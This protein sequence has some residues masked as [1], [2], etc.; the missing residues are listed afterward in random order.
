MSGS[1]QPP[2]VHAANVLQRADL[3]AT[4][5]LV[6]FDGFVDGIIDVVAERRS[7]RAGDY[8]R[9][10]SIPAFASR[11]AAAAGLSTN[12]EI[13]VRDER[14][15]GNG[16][17][18]AGALAAAGASTSFVGCVGQADAGAG[19]TASIHPLFADLKHRCE[20]TRGIVIPISP[21]ALTHALEFD[22][23]KIMLNDPRNVQGVSWAT[24]RDRREVRELVQNAQLIA[25]VNWTNMDSVRDILT[26]LVAEW[27]GPNSTGHPPR[28]QRMFIDLSDPA[29]RS[30]PDLRQMLDTLTNINRITP[31]TLG[32]NLSEARQVDA[33]LTGGKSLEN[34]ERGDHLRAGAARLR[35]AAGV[36][37][38][39]IHPR[40]GAAGAT[41]SG[42]SAWVDGPLCA[43]PQISTGAGDHFNAGFSL[44]QVIGMPL[45]ACLALGCATSGAYVRDA[46]SPSRARL[47]EMLL[48]PS[49]A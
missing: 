41:S 10:A 20:S 4:N 25:V 15:G 39:V 28:A 18:M 6:G 24:L 23:G 30:K 49:A 38:I 11:C 40:D 35:A 27:L 47:A 48:S 2:N 29:R 16:P 42:D 12:L 34:A 8:A 43:R 14:F 21:P 22:D 7:A 1:Q 31:V 44:G 45:A 36:E 9:L 26:G 5:V 19:N 46:V 13:V 33:V 32:L 37:T 3:S 17:L